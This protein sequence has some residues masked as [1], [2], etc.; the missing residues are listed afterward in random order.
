MSLAV[1]STSRDP[2][3]FVVDDDLSMREALESLFRAAGFPVECFAS[4][5]QFLL[6]PPTDSAACLVLDV[7]MPDLGG[8][9]LQHELTRSSRE[10]P[11]IFLTAHAD[12]PTAVRAVK[13]GAVEFF[14]KPFDD[15]ELLRTVR[16]VLEREQR[17]LAERGELA[18]LRARRARLS[19]RERQVMALIAMGRLNKQI[20][21]ELGVSENTIKAHR[22]H[23]MKK[24]GAASFAKLAFILARLG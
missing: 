14:P 1:R 10:V 24:M 2:V 9:E 20:A 21:V 7:R 22:R 19:E 5:R 11:I 12:V 8:L 23:I 6:R 15:E 3:V 18:E 17:A 16:K 4:A 13:A